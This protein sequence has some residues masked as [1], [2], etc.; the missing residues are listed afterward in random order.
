MGQFFGKEIIK[1]SESGNVL[2]LG[3]GSHIQIQGQ[4]YTLPNDITLTISGLVTHFIYYVYAEISSGSVILSASTSV[5]SSNLTKRLV[6]GFLSS[7]L[8]GGVGSLIGIEGTPVSG[9]VPFTPSIGNASGLTL[10]SL[11]GTFQVVGDKIC[12]EWSFRTT[13][14]GVGSSLTHYTPYGVDTDTNWY[15]EHYDN[16]IEFGTGTLVRTSLGGYQLGLCSRFYPGRQDRLYM[17]VK[18]PIGSLAYLQGTEL[19]INDVVNMEYQIPVNGW[20]SIPL[21]D[22]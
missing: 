4:G 7:Q 20:S 19:G 10:T 2:T 21:I 14:A 5:P 16:L 8:T 15:N 17:R 9:S 11:R 1:F 22:R 6:G 18:D 3:A 13:T 12:V